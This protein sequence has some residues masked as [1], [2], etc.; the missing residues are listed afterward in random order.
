MQA[1]ENSSIEEFDITR[2]DTS[3]KTFL[4]PRAFANCQNLK[5]LNLLK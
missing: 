2:E 1:F 3:K 5:M 4:S